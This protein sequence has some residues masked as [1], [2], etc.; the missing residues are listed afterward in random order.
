ME[1]TMYELLRRLTLK[2][3]TQEQLPLLVIALGIAELFYKFHSFLLETGA[4]LLTWLALGALYAGLKS[5]F[6]RVKENAYEN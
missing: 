3:L 5:L 1:D 4:F 6:A 2:Q